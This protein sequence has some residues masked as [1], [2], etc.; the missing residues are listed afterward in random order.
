MS[1]VEHLCQSL[2]DILST[3]L[4]SRRMRPEYGSN[5]P[6]MVDQPVSP[7]WIAAVQSDAARAIV[8]W[9]PRILLRRVSLVSLIDGRPVFR[10]EGD[11]VGESLV[12]EVTA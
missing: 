3:P 5:I 6:R 1:G 2:A 9:E 8:R 7:G 11:Y 4:G 10:I 12:L